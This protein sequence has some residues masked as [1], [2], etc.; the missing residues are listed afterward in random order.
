[1]ETERGGGGGE[2]IKSH[3]LNTK[4]VTC[5]A[6]NKEF[7]LVR[8]M[9]TDSRRHMEKV[10]GVTHALCT[11]QPCL[12]TH[13]CQQCSSECFSLYRRRQT[14]QT[15]WP[16]DGL[17]ADVTVM[18][19]LQRWRRSLRFTFYMFPN[20]LKLMCTWGFQHGQ[21]CREEKMCPCCWQTPSDASQLHLLNILV[22]RGVIGS[23]LEG[24]T[25][26]V[27][28]NQPE[29]R[30][31]LLSAHLFRVS[32]ELCELVL[33]AETGRTL[34]RD[35]Q[36]IQVFGSEDVLRW[37]CAGGYVWPVCWFLWE[38]DPLTS[39]TCCDAMHS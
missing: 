13:K 36:S 1:M 11:G 23:E 32:T 26:S 15:C 2:W 5:P 9:L 21:T 39:L 19:R 6:D 4:S 18:E 25:G 14:H 3:F 20:P 27:S 24:Q 38:L 8:R 30:N 22:K 7:D 35:R 16:S 34:V 29:Q 12:H 28:S 10:G 17:A 33:E 31:K 37:R